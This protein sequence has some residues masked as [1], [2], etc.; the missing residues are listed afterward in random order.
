MKLVKRQETESEARLKA[1][2]EA[3]NAGLADLDAGR[4]RSFDALEPLRRH[5]AALAGNAIVAKAT[6]P[7][8]K[9]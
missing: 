8:G 6:K 1:L 4:F 5:L 9:R 7:D 3:A 2:R